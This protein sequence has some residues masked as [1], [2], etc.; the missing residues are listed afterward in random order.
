MLEAL[1]FCVGSIAK[2]DFLPALT[3]FVIEDGHVRG[4]NGVMA[5]SSPIDFDIACKP[6]ADTLIKAISVCEDVIQLSLTPTGRLS[7][8]SGLF[9]VLIPCVQDTTIHP[10]PQGEEVPIDG[11]VF[12]EGVKKLDPFMGTDASRLWANGILIREKSLFA[13]NNIVLTQYW[14]GFDFGR[15]L[16]IPRE[17]IKQIIRIGI[18]PTR[19]QL[20][21]T[22]LTLHYDGSGRWLRTQLYDASAWPNIQAILE[23]TAEFKTIDKS[24]FVALEKLRPSVQELGAVY[25][26]GNKIT[27]LPVDTDGAEHGVNSMLPAGKYNVDILASIES[28]AEMIDWSHYPKRCLFR[29]DRIRGAIIGLK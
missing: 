12:F 15:P 28:I 6:K 4:F 27:T 24:I 11:P 29:G 14:N 26:R 16:V 9:K 13:T 18:P 19:A 7:V 25:F 17:A 23:G 21:E 5:L 3:H 10:H 22:S 20:T 1:K 8:K 2:K